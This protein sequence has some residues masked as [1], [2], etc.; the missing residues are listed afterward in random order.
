MDNRQEFKRLKADLLQKNEVYENML[1]N[2]RFED[3]SMSAKRIL[4]SRVHDTALSAYLTFR[5]FMYDIMLFENGED[6]IT[7]L[8]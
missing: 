5:T 2:L 1:K 6:D 7:P 3:I 4:L 8:Q